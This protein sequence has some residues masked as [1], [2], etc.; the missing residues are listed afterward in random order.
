MAGTKN[1]AASIAA[2]AKPPSP[3]KAR[4]APNMREKLKQKTG[5][6]DPTIRVHGF[7]EPF[8]LEA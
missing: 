5:K 8:A 4:S 7:E 3:R 6:P 1:K 2:K